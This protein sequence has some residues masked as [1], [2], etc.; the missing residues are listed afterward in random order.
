LYSFEVDE[1]VTLTDGLRGKIVEKGRNG[2]YNVLMEDGKEVSG[3]H[4][5]KCF[6]FK[7]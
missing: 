2:W 4:L 6:H 1:Y 3:K 5:N 7:I